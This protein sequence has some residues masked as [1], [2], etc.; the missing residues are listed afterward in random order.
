LEGDFVPG[1]PGT[2]GF[3]P[4]HLLLPLSRDKGTPGQE[5]FIVP[6]QRDNGT[7][8]PVETL[9]WTRLLDCIDRTNRYWTIK[10]HI[11]PNDCLNFSNKNQVYRVKE[12]LINSTM[13]VLKEREN[14]N[15][16][17]MK[18]IREIQAGT[19]RELKKLEHE[20]END[21][22]LND[23]DN[24]KTCIGERFNKIDARLDS[25]ESTLANISTDLGVLLKR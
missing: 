23:V 2:E 7:S 22:P 20:V 16:E 11:P 18:N 21:L 8:R 13:I 10:E 12:E 1:R 4:G 9:I 15:S 24:E 3:V 19:E 17:L 5:N 14:I 6:G 25:L